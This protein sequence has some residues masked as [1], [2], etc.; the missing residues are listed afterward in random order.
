KDKKPR[1]TKPETS[2]SAENTLDSFPTPVRHIQPTSSMEQMQKFM[3]NNPLAGSNIA[4]KNMPGFLLPQ[5]WMNPA[6]FNPGNWNR[7]VLGG[8]ENLN[9]NFPRGFGNWNINVLK[10][11]ETGTETFQEVLKCGTTFLEVLETGT[12]LK[13]PKTTRIFYTAIL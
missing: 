3:F 9:R 6:F 5:S 8:I 11:L 7:N 13:E 2:S 10:V 12:I 1:R 4:N